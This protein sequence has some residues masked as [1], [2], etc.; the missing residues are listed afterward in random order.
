MLDLIATERWIE[1]A[2][3]VQTEK[4]SAVWKYVL[5][6][7]FEPEDEDIELSQEDQ[8]ALAMIMRT[9]VDALDSSVQ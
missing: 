2:A 9:V 4:Q 6:C 1:R 7:L 8:G 3:I 5:E